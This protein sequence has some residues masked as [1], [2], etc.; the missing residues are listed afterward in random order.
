MAR[1]RRSTSVRNNS[2]ITTTSIPRS[3]A[4]SLPAPITSAI[5]RSRAAST[6]SATR[7]TTCSVR[8]SSASTTSGA[9]P[10][11]SPATT[12]STCCIT[13]RRVI[14][15]VLVVVAGE[16]VGN[17]PEVVLAE[18]GLTEQVVDLVALV[19]DAALDRVIA[20]VI[21][22][23]KEDAELLGIDVVVMAELFLTEVD[24]RP[25]AIRRQ[26]HVHRGLLERR[27]G[28]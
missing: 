19:V 11:S 20:E 27:G 18:L 3:S 22:A 1:G 16:E 17:A 8:P 12:T 10:T 9:L 7:S 14:Q 21:G 2:A 15:H 13:R 28:V 6:T 23:G 4:S 24:R 5:T 26:V 25:R